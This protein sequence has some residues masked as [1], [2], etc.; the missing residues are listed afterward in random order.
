MTA[1]YRIDYYKTAHRPQYPKG[2]S[3]VY[4]GFTPRSGKLAPVLKEF[5]DE[6]I[7]WFGVQAFIKDYLIKEWNDTFFNVNKQ[8]AVGDYK[9]IMDNTLGPNAVAVD[10]LEALHDL[11][12]LPL[13]IKSIEE[14]SRVNLKVPVLTVT[15]TIPK[16][17]WLPGYLETVLSADL[18]KPSTTA[19][20]AYEYRELLEK[21]A[22]K[23]GAP[24]EFVP[25]QGHD[26]SARGM[27]G[28]HDAA[29]S[30]MGHLLSFVGS[31]TV[32]AIVA[33]EHFYGA[34]VE[35]ELV[36]CSIPASEHSTMTF[37]GPEGEY[38][39][40]KRLITEVH[41]DGLVSL[42]CDGFDFWKVV[43]ETL[44]SMKEII[45]NRPRNGLGLSKV[46]VRP[47]CYSEDTYIYTNSGWKLFKDLTNED[48][49]AQ[50]LDDGSYEFVKPIK[51]VE[52][53]Y[54]GAMHHFKDFHGKVDILV[55]PNHRMVIQQGGKD[56]V[57]TA[58][59][60][61]SK[62]HCG[63][64]M[65]RSATAKK[66]EISLSDLDRIRI[67]F[68]A[69]GSYQ[70]AGNS[71]RFSFAKE[72]KIKRLKMLLDN[73]K[74]SY[75]IY[76][77]SDNRVEFN[78]K[79]DSNLFSKD[80]SWVNTADLS[81]DWCKQF[82]EEV[83]HWDSCVR[84]SGRI[85]FDSTT[86]S[87]VDVVEQIAMSAGYGVML[88]VY[89]DN[90]KE[91][92]STLYTLNILKSNTIGGQSWTNNL[93]NYTGKVYC[94]QVPTGKILVKRNRCIL[95]CGNSGDP[96]QIICGTAD[97]FNLDTY[98]INLE[99]CKQIAEDHLV[100]KVSLATPHG[101]GGVSEVSGYFSF[102][103]KIYKA[104]VNIEWGRY[105]KQFYYID[106]SSLVS[107]VEYELTPE[108][109]G[110]VECLWDTFGGTTT[111]KGYK[112]LNEHIGVIYGDSITLERA[113]EILK[114]LES[115]GFA[116]NN[117]VFGIGSFTYNYI[118]RDSFGFAMKSV[119]GEVTHDGSVKG[120]NI[121]KDPKTDNGTKK[122]ACGLMRVEKEVDGNY[123]LFDKQTWEEESQG[124]LQTVFLDGNL[125]KETT[126][127]EIRQRLWG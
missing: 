32:S 31:D 104:V 44:P 118:T 73:I 100:E 122:S 16:F 77:L 123:V 67:A 119:Y 110:T 54:C 106:D 92:F 98:N 64:K 47:D 59:M 108:E 56:R 103:S 80:L 49:V 114:R 116:S 33:A 61:K 43:T 20:I 58:N 35:K 8:K 93:V 50:V 46:V 74:A 69:D 105:D 1:P 65:Y 66:S 109:K 22:D 117:I 9:R 7:V 126:L 75:K 72:R 79:L 42:V 19:T 40:I 121:F 2:T 26:F 14:G 28:R 68:Q 82:I 10:H 36:G 25:L 85:K 24:E 45:E 57:V 21:F 97:I 96:V 78:V 3:K 27:S 41:P 81:E 127:A 91:H 17:F 30:G 52:Q 5:W 120:Y 63:Q 38:E 99:I 48:L 62:G 102:N 76:E 125:T 83:S 113:Y 23:T 86:K 6:K 18:W 90:R 55:T 13:H 101:E 112:V 60:L 71:I 84:N 15:N 124:E 11:G 4:N 94:V 12:Y 89:E 95:V 107:F 111:E 34:N 51:Y 53:E 39:T 70:S 88:S 37:A 29:L 115:K 87:V